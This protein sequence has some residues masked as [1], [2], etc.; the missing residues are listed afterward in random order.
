MLAEALC[1]RGHVPV[2]WWD[3]P[4][5]ACVSDDVDVA[6]L[7]SGK[8]VHF[9]RAIELERRGVRVVNAPRAHRFSLDKWHQAHVFATHDIAHPRTVLGGDDLAGLSEEVVIKPRLGSSG[10]GV[11]RARRGAVVSE[12]ELA[13]EFL[14]AELDHRV[15]VVGDRCYGWARRYPAA[16]DFRSNL[17]KG[18][19]MEV[20][21][22]PSQQAE[23]LARAAT[24]ALGLTLGGVDIL[25]ASSGSYVLEVNA[26]TTL[27]GPSKE[28]TAQ[29]LEAF[30][31]E[32]ER[33]PRFH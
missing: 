1:D 13:Q 19:R 33:T 29:I 30:I 5:G 18:A 8:E 12:S 14:Q 27:W 25:T 21:E 26:A 9:E 7:R 6:V 32:L 3:H 22:P 31:D 16:G 28:A 15:T 17:D 10:D 20:S 24:R 4:E 11:R 23:E 2:L